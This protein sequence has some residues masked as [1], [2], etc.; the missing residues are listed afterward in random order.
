MQRNCSL[1]FSPATLKAESLACKLAFEICSFVV[2]G[3][4]ECEDMERGTEA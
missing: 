1:E 3:S 4:S 2:K